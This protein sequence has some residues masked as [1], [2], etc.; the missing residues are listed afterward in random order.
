MSEKVPAEIVACSLCGKLVEESE[1]IYVER[2]GDKPRPYCLECDEI[3]EI[4]EE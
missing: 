3:D 1:A 4:E 2:E